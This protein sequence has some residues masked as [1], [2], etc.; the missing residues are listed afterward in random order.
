MATE[1]NELNQL[2]AQWGDDILLT[3]GAGGNTSFKTATSLFI[4]ASGKR[5]SRAMQEEIF[6]E[7]DLA[8]LAAALATGREYDFN[9]GL[10]G[11]LR[12]SIETP[13][14]AVIPHRVVV[15][16]HSVRTLAHA[17]R[18]DA[19]D[20]LGEKLSS[21][22]WAWVPYTKP[23]WPLTFEL[24]KTLGRGPSIWVLQN[25]GLIVAGDSCSAATALLGEVERRLDLPQSAS[26]EPSATF[27]QAVS[28]SS[29]WRLP[30]DSGVHTLALDQ[31]SLDRVT[32]GVPYPDQVV[33]LGR[34]IPVLDDVR[35]LGALEGR[36]VVL[37]RGAGVVVAR[38]AVPGVDDMLACL[39][40]ICA[41]LPSRIELNYLGSAEVDELVN[42]DAEKYRQA[43][44]SKGG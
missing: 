28:E 35:D 42:W 13:L 24:Q 32:R 29:V 15:H 30:R 25:H 7:M 36:P 31:D 9:G 43:V 21:L 20:I 11:P 40:H 34:S 19:E 22:P 10:S 39:S 18:V 16:L 5:L 17:V 12:G 4:K 26:K 6:L 23:G 27:L 1:L 44:D 37:V 8:P 2:S 14:H 41:R 3:Q 38:D 33:F